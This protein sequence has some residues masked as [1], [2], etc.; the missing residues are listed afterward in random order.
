[1]KMDTRLF[2][3]AVFATYAFMS[4]CGRTPSTTTV[5]LTLTLLPPKPS[6][7]T[8]PLTP[9]PPPFEPSPTSPGKTIVVASATDSGPDTLRQALEDAQ[10]GD[11]ITFDPAVFPPDA[12]ETIAVTSGLPGLGQGYLT[13]DASN[14][15]VILDGA[16]LPR[17]TWIPGLEI[18][19][20]GN[21]IRGMQVINFTGTGIVVALHGQN[22]TIGGDRNI[23]TGPIGQGNLVSGNDYGI[24]LWDYPS[25]NL[26]TG[27][28]I[29]TDVRGAEALGN[30]SYGVWVSEGAHAN[31]IGPDNVVAYNNGPG[32][33]VDGSETVHNTITQNSIHDN[34]RTGMLLWEGGNRQLAAPIVRDFD[35]QAR[36]LAGVTCTNCTVE[37]FSDNNDEGAIYEGQTI[38]DSTGFFTFSKEAPFTGPRL[39]ATATDTDGN[40]S[41]FSIPTTGAIK[42]LVLQQGNDLPWAILEP[43]PS[44]QLEDNRIATLFS[45]FSYEEGFDIVLYSQGI[46]R[47]RASINGIEAAGLDWSMP[48]LSISPGQD[49]VF[50][51][52]ADNGFVITYVLSFWDKATYPDGSGAPCPRFK[53]EED[54]QRYLEFVRIIVNHF[55]DRVQIYEVWNEPDNRDCP[56]WIEVEDYINLV[57]RV[58]PVIQQEYPEAK[59]Q[60]GGTSGLTEPSSEIYLFRILESDI[61][62]LVDIVSWHPFYGNSPQYDAE[63]YYA[64]PS[65]VQEIKDVATAHG[66]NGEYEAD[67]MQW[68]TAENAFPD[69][70][71]TYSSTVAA[72]YH[73]RG[74]LMHLG[75]DVSAGFG[76]EYDYQI[77]SI[78]HVTRYLS[79]IMAGAGPESLPIQVQSTAT[80][81]VSYTFSL[82][83]G[84]HS[85]ALWTD[86]VAGDDDPGVN[87]TLT[88]PGSLARRVIGIDVLH[89]FEQPL[90]SEQDG[91]GLAIR[92]L[93]VKDYPIILR[94]ID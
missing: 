73:G 74:I 89:G 67:E 46:K 83:N 91:T 21:T 76:A 11:T 33:D 10:P 55:K 14:A 41:E 8:I 44:R 51:R 92:D 7:T 19:S 75:M 78:V 57:Q 29:G 20:D 81:I 62:P 37:F 66:F 60:V 93:L 69:D 71:W 88:F 27:N 45:G 9:S 50:T 36:T 47:A 12:P 39:T 94:L 42:S 80:N 18:V 87:T 6:P 1:M 17:D 28:L 82:P 13:I 85:I 23:G 72:K 56:Q 61:M 58:V 34:G 25:N 3:F 2:L 90:V 38:A 48:E 59:I 32:I 40:T 77:P 4:G 54:I 5:S 52:L 30:R 24:G 79:T 26:V 49:D 31:I 64:Y 65:M 70:P 22:N 53:T 68:R 16:Q 43:R 86:G 63:Y 84:D 35:M 15:G